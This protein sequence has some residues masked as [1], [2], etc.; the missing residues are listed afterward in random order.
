MDLVDLLLICLVA[1]GC[2]TLGQLTSEYSRGGW[3]VYIIISF[4]GAFLGVYGARELNAP[5]LY[6]L[7][8]AETDF[9]IIWAVGGSVFFVAAVSLAVRPS[10]R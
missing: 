5:D 2:G 9:P 4:F 8:F 1:I 6:N 7:K 10:R 3:I